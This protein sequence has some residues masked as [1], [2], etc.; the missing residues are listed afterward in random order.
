MKESQLWRHLAS[1]QK[2]KKDWHFFRI[3][4]STINGIP[5]V[6]GCMNGVEIWLELKSGESKNYGLSKYQ[7]NWH[8]ERLCCGGNVFILLFT[9][10]LKS[11]KILRL[12]HRAF[13][14]RQEIKFQL[15][16]SC[17]FSEK[18]L[19]RLLTDVII[20]QNLT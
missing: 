9:P 7:I 3:E 13:I 16:G 18:N 5:D 11:L 8:I 12:V 2:T 1:I 10:K 20:W 4:S 17:K 14:L 15:L 19:E 6:N